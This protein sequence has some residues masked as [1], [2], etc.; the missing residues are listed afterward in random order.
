MINW[1]A[2]RMVCIENKK[3]INF[4]NIPDIVYC[5]NLFAQHGVLSAT[6]CRYAFE[7]IYRTIT[8]ANNEHMCMKLSVRPFIN[9]FKRNVII[10]RTN[11]KQNSSV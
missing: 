7:S 2:F 6:I 8:T 10:N 11:I 5:T 3:I 4:N 9:K 1:Y